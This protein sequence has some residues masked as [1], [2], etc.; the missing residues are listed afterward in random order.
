MR[1]ILAAAVIAAPMAAQA[2]STTTLFFD[3]FETEAK[4][5]SQAQNFTAF[6]NFTVS[7]GTV[8]FFTNGG[9]SLPCP[10]FGCVDMDGSRSSSGEITTTQS[11]LFEVGPV[12][13]VT[14]NFAGNQ[15][16]AAA[17]RLEVG[18]VGV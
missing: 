8:D 2:A 7:D 17:D 3:D 15:R 14:I 4:S 6:V 10:S 9:F 5:T 16:R 1:H 18:I 13:D 12:Y 11:F